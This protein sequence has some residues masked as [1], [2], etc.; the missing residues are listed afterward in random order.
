MYVYDEFAE[1]QGKWNIDVMARA[2][3]GSKIY[4]KHTLKHMWS[5]GLRKRERENRYGTPVPPKFK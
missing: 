3:Q 1:K 2:E 4:R 5:P